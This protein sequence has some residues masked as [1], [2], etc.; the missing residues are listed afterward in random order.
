M[1]N[2]HLSPPFSGQR[3]LRVPERAMATRKGPLTKST[4]GRDETIHTEIEQPTI[5]RELLFPTD[6][7]LRRR[8]ERRERLPRFLN[9]AGELRTAC[10]RTD[11]RR[12]FYR[13]H[14]GGLSKCTEPSR[15]V[16]DRRTLDSDTACG[17]TRRLLIEHDRIC[18]WQIRFES[19][20]LR[21]SDIVANTVIAGLTPI[22]VTPGG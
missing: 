20:W 8:H 18:G 2:D 1:G 16:L 5:P 12:Q 7:C 6:E 17:Q 19:S 11:P 15:G 13:A 3:T 9:S 10:V 22:P 4:S 14:S 21:I